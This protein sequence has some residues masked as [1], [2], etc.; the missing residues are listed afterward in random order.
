MSNE[1]MQLPPGVYQRAGKLYHK[2]QVGRESGTME[3]ERE[4]SLSLSEAKV[5]R[6]DYYHH[7]LGWIIEGWKLATDRGSDSIMKDTSESMSANP[8]RENKEGVSL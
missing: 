8:D 6:L 4:V 3:Y 7:E 1:T 5:K 2:R